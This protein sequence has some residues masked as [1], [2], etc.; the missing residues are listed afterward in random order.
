MK[1]A[2]VTGGGS[3]IGRGVARRLHGDGY[4]VVVADVSADTAQRVANE[5][6][7]EALVVD[8]ADPSALA[9]GIGY[10]TSRHPHIDALVNCAGIWSY[11]PIEDVSFEDARRVIEV[12]VLGTWFMVQAAVAA[13]TSGSAIVNLSSTAATIAPSGVGLYPASKGAIEALTRQLA[14]ELGA[15]GIRVN[16]VAPGL[17][18]T[19]ATEHG[20]ANGARQLLGRGLPLGRHGEPE[21][22]ASV[23]SFLVSDA[24]AYVTGQTLAVDGGLSL[25]GLAPGAAASTGQAH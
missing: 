14:V 21:D 12:N 8:I 15:R 19:E 11:A 9:T 10:V 3:G 13:M 1:T 22:V 25:V 20:Y 18:R 17:I 2:L 4:H 24:A 23:I 5:V 16:A 6:D 7:G